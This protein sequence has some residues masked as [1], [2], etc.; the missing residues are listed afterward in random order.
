MHPTFVTVTLV[1]FSFLVA[2]IHAGVG[3]ATLILD[4]EDVGTVFVP[5][6][7]K[8]VPKDESTSFGGSFRK[9]DD[10]VINAS[11]TMSSVVTES[12]Q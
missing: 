7:S 5:G 2:H 3:P 8:W 4:T 11:I 12:G 1:C 6:K 9:A 10:S